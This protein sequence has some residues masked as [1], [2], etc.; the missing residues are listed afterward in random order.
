M[1]AGIKYLE[2]KLKD[3]GTLQN[4]VNVLLKWYEG[5]DIVFFRTFVEQLPTYLDVD[6]LPPGGN[7]GDALVKVSNQDGDVT[8]AAISGSGAVT[9]GSILGTL[10]NQTDLQSALNTKQN[11]LSEGE[12][13]NGDKTKLDNITPNADVTNATT[14]EAAGALMDN[15]VV[16]LNAVKSF[17]PADY[18]TAA[19]GAKADSALQSS[20]IGVSVQAH[21][22]VL[23]NTTE[24]YTST[25]KTKLDNIEEG[26]DVTDFTNVQA[27]GALMDSEV[28]NLSAVKTFDPADY[29]T[30]AQGIKADSALQSGASI[31]Q[32]TGTANRLLYINNFGNVTE[33]S[34]GSNGTFLQSQGTTSPPVW[35]TIISG[36]DATSIQGEPVTSTTPTDGQILVYRTASNSYVLETKPVA[37]GNPAWG[38]IT[39]T[40]SN[41]T[42]LQ[43]AL[44]DKQNI[45]LEGAFV[46][47]DKTKLDGIEANADVTDATNVNAAG[48]VM[49]SD[50]NQSHSVLV[51]QNS[52]GSPS[53]VNFNNNSILGKAGGDISALTAGEVRSIINVEDGA[54]VT[55]TDNVR[56]AGALM[57][58]EVTNLADVKAFDPANYATAA[59]GTK[60]DSAVQNTGDETI[61]GNKTFDR[62][63]IL[64]SPSLDNHGATKKYVDDAIVASGGYTDEQAQDAVGVMLTSTD[65]IDLQY[66]DANQTVTANLKDE[67][68]I[69]NRLSTSVQSSLEKADSSIQTLNVSINTQSGNNYTLVLADSNKYIRCTNGASVAVT[70]PT[71]ATVAFAIG[72]VITLRQAGAGQITVSGAG[73]TLNGNTKSAEQHA[74]L[75]LVKV[76]TDTWDIIG[77]IA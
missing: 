36:S 53:V 28:A 52:S 29:A 11:I 60:A 67:S 45:L 59:Q 68:I 31:T 21:S 58:D 27:A 12:F 15:E 3:A 18:A 55:D 24:S 66:N 35:A 44:N 75:Q 30:A 1:A 74:S 65:E 38:D 56:S 64:P 40:L 47:G 48:A 37:S 54:D 13:V 41:Q 17:D 4:A 32:L 7:T 43:N 63:P 34:L 71:N 61:G 16:N 50:Y 73:V 39:G 46:N 69:K 49:N 76:D 23:D 10:S 42:D 70:I 62:S 2:Q 8:W 19:Q 57:D 51:Q 72:T 22:T 26:A 77:G 6:S 33:L 5:N 20:D 25:D 14:V 9:W